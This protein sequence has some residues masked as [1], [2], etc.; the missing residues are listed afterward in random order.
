MLS[1]IG[2]FLHL[3][4]VVVGDRLDFRGQL[5]LLLRSAGLPVQG[6]LHPNQYL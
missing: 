6:F 2:V 1:E 4:R 5:G 3:G